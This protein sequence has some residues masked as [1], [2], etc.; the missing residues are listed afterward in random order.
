MCGY[1]PV[2]HRVTPGGLCPA[3]PT[4]PH[5]HLRPLSD[6][7]TL[8]LSSPATPGPC[9]QPRTSWKTSAIC[10]M[11][12]PTSWTRCWTETCSLLPLL[13]SGCSASA[14]QTGGERTR[15]RVVPSGLPGHLHPRAPP[16][17]HSAPRWECS[18]PSAHPA[19]CHTR[20]RGRG[21]VSEGV[22]PFPPDW[23]QEESA[24]GLHTRSWRPRRSPHILAQS[25][26]ASTRDLSPSTLHC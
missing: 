13:T 11:T 10:S 7:L 12:W 26:G 2:P 6:V 17:Q 21:P 4:P 5:Q 9:T 24:E 8:S 18:R 19:P 14:L 23:Q 25:Q 1:T 22:R 3:W 20:R 16:S 15:H